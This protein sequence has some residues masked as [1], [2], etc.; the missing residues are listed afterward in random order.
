[1]KA[2]VTG[3]T[4]FV[5]GR[6]AETLS[7]RG[8]GVRCLVRDT[9]RA[10]HLADAGHELHE[11]DVLKP[12][13]LAGAGE[14][15]DVAYYLVHSMG[16]GSGDGFEERERRAAR[17]FAEMASREGVERVV[18]LGGLGDQPQSE[19][20]RSRHRTAAILAEHRPSLTYFRAAMVVGA[21]SEGYKTL[22]YLVERLP[23]MLAP[24]WLATTTQPIAI[25]DAIEYLAQAPSIPRSAGREVQ[26]GGPD[27]L[28]YGEMLDEMARVLG[29]R[30]RPK[31]PVPVL[32][33]GLSARWIGLVTPVDA[34]VARPLVEGLSTRTVVTDPSGM[35]PFDVEPT[36]LR[37]A[38]RRACAEGRGAVPA[39]A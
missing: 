27:V 31:L 11:G 16:R 28:S 4:G 25:D 15:V 2:L 18:Y 9:G 14:G 19:H 35:E 29:K 36:S 23:A 22:R 39:A 37:E 7:A 32:S 13:T 21:E 17:A 6:L 24:R 33:P 10:Q 8:A 1:M 26:I 20:L 38:L 12:E 3:A 5:G 30:P 34:G